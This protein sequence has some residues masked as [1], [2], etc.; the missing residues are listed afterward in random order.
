MQWFFGELRKNNVIRGLYLISSC[1]ISA[2]VSVRIVPIEDEHPGAALVLR[3]IV[4]Q[5]Q[6]LLCR[7]ADVQL[8]YHGKFICATH[9]LLENYVLFCMF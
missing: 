6:N 1:P 8:A 3:L 7:S 5:L 2:A 9:L 4:L